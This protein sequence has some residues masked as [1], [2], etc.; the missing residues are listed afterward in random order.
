MPPSERPIPQFIA[1]PPREQ[2]PYGRW[3]ETLA[4][5]FLDA[6]SR[7]DAE[8]D[9]GEP[10]PITWFPDRTLW[11]RTYVPCTA[12]TSNGFELFGVVSF[13][14]EHDGAEARDF[15]AAVDY[16]D[17][18]AEANP[19]WQLDLSDHELGHWRGP[20]GR[21]GE[22]A[23][24]W[25]VALV[26]NGAVATAELGPTT[27]DQCV[28]VDDRFTLVSLDNYGGDY[29]EVKLWGAGGGELA[30]ESLYEDY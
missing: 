26:A 7:L 6:A 1:E 29:L 28:L 30:S 5:H 16:T 21:T 11:G 4:G 8:D 2:L 27:T 22:I 15:D 13:T 3:A 10:G 23:I 14:R 12:P 9:L 17:E 24:V 20:G 19:D 25:G 18:T